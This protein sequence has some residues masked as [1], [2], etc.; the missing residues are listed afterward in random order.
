[1]IIIDSYQTKN[2]QQQMKIENLSFDLAAPGVKKAMVFF[3]IRLVLA[4]TA[5]YF[6][7]G[8]FLKKE[9]MIDQPLTNFIT[10]AVVKSIDIISPSASPVTSKASTRKPGNN[11]IQNNKT[12]LAIYDSCNSIDLIFT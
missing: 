7:A 11:L 3:F 9:R 5:W 10:N 6:I 8:T 4:F 12:V 2:D 1:M